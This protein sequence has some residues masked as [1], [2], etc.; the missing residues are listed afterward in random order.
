MARSTTRAR[1]VVVDGSNIATEG[2]SE[3]SLEQLDT[4]ITAFLE[5]FPEYSTS[6][7]IVVVD[8]TFEHRIHQEERPTFEAAVEHGEVVSPPAGTI[9]RGDAFILRIA[10]KASAVVVS[11]DSFQEF[12]AEH[13]W[14]F[15][16][17]RLVGGKPVPGVGWVFAPRLP[18]RGPRS[19]AAVSAQRRRKP[20]KA[21]A[22]SAAVDG[23]VARAKPAPAKPRAA[24]TAPAKAAPAK[25]APPKSGGPKPEVAATGRGRGGAT[26]KAGAKK[27]ATA[28]PTGDGPERAG[29]PDEAGGAAAARPRR[30]GSRRAVEPTADGDGSV[31][32]GRAPSSAGALNEPLAFLTFVAEHPVGSTV[33]GDVAA[34]TSHGAHVDVGDMR[35]HVPLRGLADPPP[36]RARDVVKRGETRRFVVVGIDPT[37]RRADLALAPDRPGGSPGAQDTGPR[38]LRSRC[39]AKR[40]FEGHAKW[41]Y[42][43]WSAESTGCGDTQRAN[44][45][46]GRPV[47]MP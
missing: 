25:A 47:G 46:H 11:N 39:V 24:K 29:G 5:E 8:A 14:L 40:C 21:E 27:A 18:V 28:A 7:V 22:E 36:S 13:P 10:D 19:R 17:G 34:F 38:N 6:D 16:E 20:A 30:A 44:G 35:C 26:K 37:G 12:H 42:Y 15:D 43:P 2:R 3:P 33:T 41:Y 31:P 23:A 9:G 32:V 4:A 1:T 45:E